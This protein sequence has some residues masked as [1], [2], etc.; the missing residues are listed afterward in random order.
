MRRN[1]PL[2]QTAYILLV[3]P[4]HG[5]AQGWDDRPKDHGATTNG[6]TQHK[7]PDAL[8]SGSRVGNCESVWR[9]DPAERTT[10]GRG[11]PATM[12][13]SMVGRAS[14]RRTSCSGCV[15]CG[16]L[17]CAESDRWICRDFCSEL[18]TYHVLERLSALAVV[19]TRRTPAT[20]RIVISGC[21]RPLLVVATGLL[22]LRRRSGRWGT[23]RS[24]VTE[25]AS[26]M[27]DLSK[28]RRRGRTG[29]DIGSS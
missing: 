3:G 29:K 13:K 22:R 21:L 2:I 27:A 20:T 25:T 15:C 17:S 11:C 8:C 18:E 1:L 26:A 6:F 10:T 14:A 16:L 19:P 28:A 23:W 24:D 5:S 7:E 12:H 4:G 9:Q